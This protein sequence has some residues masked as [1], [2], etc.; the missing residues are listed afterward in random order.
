MHSARQG[1]NQSE[2]QA[3]RRDAEAQ[4]KNTRSKPE[5]AERAE[6]AEGAA[7]AHRKSSQ[8]PK[9]FIIG[10]TDQNRISLLLRALRLCNPFRDLSPRHR[11]E[12]HSDRLFDA[13]DMFAADCRLQ[14]H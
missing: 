10:S 2:T 6:S 3:H 5:S 7:G 1:R 14:L 9:I 4:K 11:G 8:L 13:F 12:M